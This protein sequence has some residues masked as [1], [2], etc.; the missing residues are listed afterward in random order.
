MV[1]EALFHPSD[2][3]LN[4]AGVAQTIVQAVEATHP[5]LHALLYAN[6]LLTGQK[7]PAV[8]FLLVVN[9]ECIQHCMIQRIP[10]PHVHHHLHAREGGTVNCPGFKDRLYA[11]LRPLV[12]DDYSLG[13]HQPQDPILCAWQG[14]SALAATAGFSSM[15]TSKAEYEERGS[16]QLG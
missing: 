10:K 15:A 6:I 8:D 4:Q 7:I 3:G 2:V 16:M 12:P 13:I 14:A 9:N 1:P 5:H 11:E